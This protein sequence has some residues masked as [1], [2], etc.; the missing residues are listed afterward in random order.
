MSLLSAIPLAALPS[1][2]TPPFLLTTKSSSHAAE[3]REPDCPRFLRGRPCKLAEP[4]VQAHSY[5]IFVQEIM[6]SLLRATLSLKQAARSL[7]QPRRIDPTNADRG[8]V[9]E[10][11]DS[12]PMLLLQTY[13]PVNCRPYLILGPPCNR[14]QGLTIPIPPDWYPI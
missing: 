8:V 3:G 12:S 11:L 1:S 5:K 7:M 14:S 6:V 10:L 13:D 4:I 2:R 9:S